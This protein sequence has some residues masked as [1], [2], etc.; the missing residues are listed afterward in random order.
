MR[1]NICDKPIVENQ[2][3]KHNNKT[4]AYLNFNVIN[5]A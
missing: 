4:S 3:I 5:A 2:N 1:I